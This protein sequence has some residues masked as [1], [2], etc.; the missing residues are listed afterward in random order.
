M[1]IRDRLT[2]V[3]V[4]VFEYAT[5][6][7]LPLAVVACRR[8]LHCRAGAEKLLK[9]AAD[10]SRVRRRAVTAARSARRRPV[11]WPCCSRPAAISCSVAERKRLL[12]L[13]RCR[14]LAR[15]VVH[16]SVDAANLVDDAV[17]HS[18]EQA[19]RQFGPVRSHEV[20][21]LIHIWP[22]RVQAERARSR[23]VGSHPSEPPGG[24]AWPGRG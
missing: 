18:A 23:R 12:P 8:E 13:D 10:R 5:D 4:T 14:R 17:R 1:C 16:H 20:L 2:P 22:T 11:S 15:Y 9:Q 24:Y 21:S 6:E 3:A 7:H 19:V